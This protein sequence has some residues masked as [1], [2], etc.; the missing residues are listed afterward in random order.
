MTHTDLGQGRWFTLSLAEQLG[1][2]GSEYERAFSWKQRGD[3]SKHQSAFNRFLELLDLTI[4]DPRTTATR[5]N[6]LLKVREIACTEMMSHVPEKQ[7]GKYFM[8]F[9]LLARAGK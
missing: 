3:S 5:K 6:E 8:Q 4:A 2:V 9:A 1:N 7:L